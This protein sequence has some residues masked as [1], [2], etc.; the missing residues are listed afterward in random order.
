MLIS[1]PVVCYSHVLGTLFG[2]CGLMVV[3]EKSGLL[4]STLTALAFVL[5]IVSSFRTQSFDLTAL[6]DLG[7]FSILPV[8]FFVA[9]G[10]LIFSFFITLKTA[11]KSQTFLL[12]LQSVLLILFINLTPA[13][14]EGT[15][16]FS[17]GYSNF[18]SVDYIE[19]FFSINPSAIWIHNWPTF[20]IFIA[21]FN[22]I[23]TLPWDSL[24][25]IYPTIF[26]ILLLPA[27]YVLLNASGQKSTVTWLG[28]WL[29]FLGNWVGQDYFSIQSMGFFFIVLLLFL[30][31]KSSNKNLNGR[32][33]LVLFFV[34]FAYLVT[35]HLLSSLVIVSVCLIFLLLKQT[36]RKPFFFLLLFTVIGWT[37]IDANA[38][39]SNN[40]GRISGQFLN[41][42]EIFQGNFSN[43][44]LSGSSS[45]MLAAEVRVFYSLVMILFGAVGIVIAWRNKG[46]TPYG[47]RMLFVLLGVS[48]LIF[49]FAYGGELYI[50][51]LHV[52][53]Y[54][55]ELFCC[56]N[57]TCS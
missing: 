50:A 47:K 16:R 46:F 13:I 8:T 49:A 23:S 11:K 37:V 22:Q 3:K 29:I 53:P 57:N 12:F 51:H 54:S 7:L 36:Y 5:W 15:P 33:W 18:A 55:I 32:E 6:S 9:F 44:L 34:L 4:C 56:P 20:S 24:L 48:L 42:S 38:Y 41:F 30:L 1:E 35:S 52:Q 10:L 43:R 14:I 2:E 17:A 45:H 28:I 31:F 21:I 27:L 19:D 40:L 25:L 39:L 26:N